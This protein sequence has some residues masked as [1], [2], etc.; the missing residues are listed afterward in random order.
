MP[1]RYQREGMP[2]IGD[3]LY[4]VLHRSELE[5]AGSVHVTRLAAEFKAQQLRRGGREVTVL[6]PLPA[7]LEV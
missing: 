4:V 7:R 5:E 6:G 1:L 2:E 3:T